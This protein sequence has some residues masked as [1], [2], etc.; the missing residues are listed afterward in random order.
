MANWSKYREDPAFLFSAFL[1]KPETD[2]RSRLQFSI[3]N[4]TAAIKAAIGRVIGIFLEPVSKIFDVLVGSITQSGEGVLKMR[5][6]FNNMFKK[7]ESV[8]NI[9]QRRYA[10]TAHAL[11][12]TWVKLQESMKKTFS[13]ATASLY[14]GLSVFK[15]IENSFRLMTTIAI[16]ILGILLGF[17]VW[18]FFI[19]WPI[20]PLIIMGIVWISKTPY[21]GDVMGMQDSFCF[22]PD[23][24]VITPQGGKP[25]SEIRI[26]DQLGTGEYNTKVSGVMVFE[27]ENTPLMQLHGVQ[28]SG[29]HIIWRDGEP[30]HVYDHPDATHA[31]NYSGKLICLITEQHYIPV[32]SAA[33]PL[34]FADWEEIDTEEELKR[35]YA[36][37]FETLNHAEPTDGPRSENLHSEAVLSGQ[38]R[39]ATPLGPAEI[40]NVRPGDSVLDAK[41]VPTR[42]GGV[43]RVST[44]EVKS[45]T[46]IDDKAYISAGAW[47]LRDG[48]W[49]QPQKDL[50]A[51][52]STENTWYSLFTESGTFRLACGSAVDVG[53]RDFSDVGSGVI[54]QT[55]DWVLE[56]LASR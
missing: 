6:V 51:P 49:G 40:R 36:E 26:G 24:R 17:V 22:A 38:T 12:R 47:I 32:E 14:A 56:S 13:V 21:A 4:F 29:T 54:Q 27:V 19:L 3:D 41:G 37:V 34:T 15:T 42:V 48:I 30:C 25:I 46:K 23:T 50:E 35:W 39:V 53:I 20:L 8:T 2:P 9:F 7:F 28:V 16:V 43:V 18:F 10:N 52:P 45:V 33:G 44:S 55:Y 11:R 1:F 31:G 5:G